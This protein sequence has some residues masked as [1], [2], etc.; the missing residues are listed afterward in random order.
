M[1]PSGLDKSAS[2]M[3]ARKLPGGRSPAGAGR[4]R[5]RSLRWP[6]TFWQ[7]VLV[8][9]GHICCR[10][11]PKHSGPSP[12][13]CPKPLRTPLKCHMAH[14]ATGTSTQGLPVQVRRAS[15]RRSIYGHAPHPVVDR[16]PAGPGG[17]GVVC[18][19]SRLPRQGRRLPRLSGDGAPRQGRGREAPRHRAPV[20]AGPEPRGPQAV[21]GR[22]ER[23]PGPRRGRAGG[24]LRRLASRARAPQRGDAH[25]HPRP[26]DRAVRQA[27]PARRARHRLVEQRRT[28]IVFMVNP[29]GLQHDLTGSPYRSWRRS[30]QPTPGSSKVGTDLNRNYGYRFGCC[31]GSS[32]KPGAWDYRGPSAWSAPETRAM[33]DFIASRKS[34]GSSASERTSRS[35]PPARWCFG[36]TAIRGKTY[37][38]T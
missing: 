38:R 7:R 33:R 21:G 22:G 34:K 18:G 25:L 31:G 5:H 23:Q 27:D 16:C 15:E 13:L 9:Q 14:L 28:W 19:C 37:H 17:A 32:G 6:P 4:C 29:D 8:P 10:V 26:A 24:A 11:A 20:L 35:T 3:T 36:R 2:L 30:R 1:I 12:P